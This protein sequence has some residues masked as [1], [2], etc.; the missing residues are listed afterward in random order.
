MSS[1]KLYELR[2]FR[3]EREVRTANR[4]REVLDLNDRDPET[5]QRTRDLL[6]R[7]LHAAAQ[8]AG[9]PRRDAHLY[10]FE[11]H[12]VRGEHVDNRALFQFSVPVEA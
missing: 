3:G 5:V 6:R 7:H 12:E 2:V 10:H 1:P 11:V 9:A 4:L 8:R